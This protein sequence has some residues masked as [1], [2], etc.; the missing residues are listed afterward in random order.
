M[1]HHIM[2]VIL[3]SF[4]ISVNENEY[5]QCEQLKYC[6]RNR[7]ISKQHWKL[8][9]QTI[10]FKNDYFKANIFDSTNEKELIL[11]IFFLN[12]GIRF[13]IEPYEEENFKRYDTSKDKTIIDNNEINSFKKFYN[14]RNQTH[15]FLRIDA[16][17]VLFTNLCNVIS[18]F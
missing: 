3:F 8:I 12:T 16:I 18:M 14:S 1:S 11:S 17:D 15:M 9:A 7:E 10:E 4:I 2:F 5:K 13:R 6:Y